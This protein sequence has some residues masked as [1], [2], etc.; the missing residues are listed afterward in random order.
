M[1]IPVLVI[2]QLL[3]WTIRYSKK[4][5]L[6]NETQI[7]KV[8]TERGYDI[9]KVRDTGIEVIESDYPQKVCFSFGLISKPS[10]LII[11][12]PLRMIVEV[13]SNTPQSISDG[14]VDAIL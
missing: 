8:K 12:L 4:V 11:C 5:K 10:E 9:L 3:K 7:I 1:R 2:M 14:D 6:T 13:E